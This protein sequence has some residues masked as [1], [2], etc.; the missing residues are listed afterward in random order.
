MVGQSSIGHPRAVLLKRRDGATTEA[1]PALDRLPVC[2]QCGLGS[3]RLDATFCRRCGLP[4]GA[5]PAAFADLPSCPVCYAD[6]DP[7]GRF[8]SL[9]MPG[10][11]LGLPDHQREHERFP[12]GDDDWLEAQREGDRIRVGR[13]WAS[14]DQVRRYL[15]TGAVEA[16]RGRQLA[17]DAIATAMT[18]LSRWGSNAVIMGDQP[19]WQVAR[20][21]VAELR[22]RYH[23]S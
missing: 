7:D 13:W 16:G 15:V 6:A 20:A 10:R 17:H 21:A 12:V 5:P 19:E 2:L 11:R 22:E 3:N 18:Q 23:R 1:P 4:Y 8:A 9:A 14:F